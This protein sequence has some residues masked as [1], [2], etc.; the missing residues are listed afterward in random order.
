[1]VPMC[2]GLYKTIKK[3]YREERRQRRETLAYNRE[4]ELQQMKEIMAGPRAAACAGSP[5]RP[6]TRRNR[7]RTGKSERRQ[8]SRR[9]SYVSPATWRERT[10]KPIRKDQIL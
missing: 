4:M 8:A 1:M 2:Y 7:S 10:S 6:R 9:D 5:Q 3:E